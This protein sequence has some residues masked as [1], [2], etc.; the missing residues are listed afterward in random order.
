MSSWICKGIAKDGQM[1]SNQNPPGPHE[2]YENFGSDC[3]MCHLTREQVESSKKS[4]PVLFAAA[5]TGLLAAGG[6]GIYKIL[7]S[8]SCPTG[9]HQ[10]NGICIKDAS[11][12]DT[13]TITKDSGDTSTTV[14]PAHPISQYQTFAE[15][16]DVPDMTVRYGG[17]TSFA[18]LRRSDN[19]SKISDAHPNFKLIYTEPPSGEKPGSGN[20]I[21]MLI[22]GQLSMAQSS[23][24]LKDEE[25]DR[26]KNRGIILEQVPVAIDGIALY[27]NPQISIKGLSLSQV[28][29]IFTGKITNWKQLGGKDLAIKPFS[30]AP[31]DGGTPE[32]FAEKI[33]NQASFANSVQPFARD[34]TQSLRKVASTP[35]G[36]GYA[37]ASEVCNQKIIRPLP[38]SKEANQAF[39]APCQG[40]KVNSSDFASGIYPITR[41]L[42]LIINRDGKNDEQAGIAYANLLL[43]D[44]GQKLIEQSGLVPLRTH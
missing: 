17:S 25:I 1:H 39:V 38:I 11:S 20:G 26:A 5:A 21:K 41:R 6:F 8:H 18:P 16:P 3:V 9:Q 31:N 43:S 23:R 14:K 36:I 30:R 42:F 4:R 13:K 15:V 35:G 37:S 10:I 22:E 24:G 28:K 2:P 29:D 44:E 40:M 19:I 12:A 33:M 27:V 34:T 7:G 32:Y